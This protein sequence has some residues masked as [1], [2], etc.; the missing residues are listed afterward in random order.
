VECVRELA[1]RGDV[2]LGQIADTLDS[3]GHALLCFVLTLPFVQPIPVAGLSSIIGPVIFLVGTFMAMGRKPWMPAKWRATILP[4]PVL[5]KAISI[6]A[7][8]ARF[9]EHYFRR[10]LMWCLRGR[11]ANLMIGANI[12]TSAAL[13]ALPLPIP[14]TNTLPALSIL[15]TA[16]GLLEEDGCLVLAG[17]VFLALSSC[18]FM[19]LAMAGNVFISWL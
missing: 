4:A 6:G 2:S 17:T 5:Q 15:F 8:V 19:G 1:G 14:F 12:G 13:L 18:Y 3:R 10:R 11:M 16:L 9:G 7:R